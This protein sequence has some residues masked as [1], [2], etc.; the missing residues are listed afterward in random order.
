MSR[1]LAPALIL[2]GIA[3][4]L[5]AP[6]AAEEVF[7][8]DDFEEELD[9]AWEIVN[10]NPDNFIVEDGVLLALT[11]SAGNYAEETVGNVFKLSS[12]VPDGDWVIE[13]AFE[14][15]LQTSREQII[16]GVADG[17]DRMVLGTIYTWGDKYHGW[18]LTGQV[19]KSSGG[20][21]SKFDVGLARLGC[22]VCGNDRMF[23]N[24]VESVAQPILMQLE[25]QGRQY[26]VRAKLSGPDAEWQESA[27]VTELR[28]LPTPVLFVT[29]YESNDGESLFLIDY[30]KISSM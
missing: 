10:P 24:F 22:N 12:G 27:W 16:L 3:L 30:F 23:P 20:K 21:T 9:P 11:N 15:E 17:V 4:A 13:I 18:G 7:F 6:T 5:P 26:R 14:A 25:K 8:Q 1:L 2:C 19:Y 29:Q 28:G